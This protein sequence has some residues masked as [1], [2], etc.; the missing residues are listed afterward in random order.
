MERPL[1]E[2]SRLRSLR[3]EAIG[4]PGQRTFRILAE[5]EAG[6]AIVWLEKEQLFHI[7]TAFRQLMVTIP[8]REASGP[9]PDTAALARTPL[10]L[11]AGRLAVGHD[12]SRQLFVIDVHD[13]D[14]DDEQ[15]ASLR[16]WMTRGQASDLADE[17][18]RVCASGRPT[19]PL[20]DAP[21]DADGHVCPKLNGHASGG[22]GGV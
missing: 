11:R 8:E 17:G 16:L 1:N 22:G 10:E 3:P 20:C 2:M 13:V 12:V 4:E 15:A 5:S 9:A 18:L 6:S 14:D 7:S 21:I 19:C